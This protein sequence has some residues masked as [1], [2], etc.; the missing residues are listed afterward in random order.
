MQPG[1]LEVDVDALRGIGTGVAE[2]ARTLQDAMKATG[3]G[4]APTTGT[5]S[6]A[7]TAALAAEKAWLAGLSRLTA[8]IE[9]FSRDLTAAARDYRVTDQAS[10]DGLRRS[11]SAVPR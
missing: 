1:Q 6:A 9:A 3:T 7:A 8:Q 5:P 11:G 4:L 2:A 10:A